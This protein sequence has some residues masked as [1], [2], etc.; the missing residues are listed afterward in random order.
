VKLIE[1]FREK[2]VSEHPAYDDIGGSMTYIEIIDFIKKFAKN[3][4]V[5]N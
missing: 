5:D 3:N 1:A 4:K 2:W